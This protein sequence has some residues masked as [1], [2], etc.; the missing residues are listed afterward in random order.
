M[1]KIYPIAQNLCIPRIPCLLRSPHPRDLPSDRSHNLHSLDSPQTESPTA[2]R[3][4][5]SRFSE[6]WGTLV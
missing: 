1:M 6:I 4:H 2:D 3:T 5:F